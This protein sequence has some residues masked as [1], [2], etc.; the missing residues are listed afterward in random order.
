[1]KRHTRSP[2]S[3]SPNHLMTQSLRGMSIGVIGAGNMGRALINGLV[4]NSFP[5]SHLVIVESDRQRG[6]AVRRRYHVGVASLPEVARRCDVLILAVKPQDLR[7]VLLELRK[8]LRARGKRMLVVSIAA[9][10]QTISIERILGRV[11]VVRVMPNLPATVGC[12]MA[13]LAKGRFAASA[14]LRVAKA[15]FRSVGEVVE[16]PERDFDAVTALSGSGPAYFFL[17]FQAL[18]DAG[19]H[20]GLPKGVARRL[21][22]QTAKGSAALASQTDEELEK[23]IARVASKK[24]TTEAALTVF[25]R[26]GLTRILQRGVRAA[27]KRSRELSR[28]ASV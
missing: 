21:A 14:D 11:P 9:G 20:C 27:V 8:A 26:D 6:Q 5:P 12:G 22:I 15:I 24:G 2:H 23:L 18:R 1:M 25:R 4:T 10:V 28:S 16:L 19:I 7:G 13:A 3:Q 17:I